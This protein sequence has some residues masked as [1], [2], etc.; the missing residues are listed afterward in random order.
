[1]IQDDPSKRPKMDEVIVRFEAVR[2]GLSTTQLRSRVARKSE[3]MVEATY[4][5]ILHW[6]RR[7]KYFARRT[8]ALPPLPHGD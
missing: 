3:T 5:T 4:L 1:M 8:P 6:S 7:L 2:K